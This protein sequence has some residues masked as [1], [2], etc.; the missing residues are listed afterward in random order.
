MLPTR[1]VFLVLF[2]VPTI[3]L[4]QKP[5]K[6][7]PRVRTAYQLFEAPLTSQL[8]DSGYQ[9]A[10]LQ[11]LLVG[12]KEERIL[13]VWLRT[14]TQQRYRL[15]KEYPF[16]STSG[17]LG[18]KRA[19]GDGQIPEGIYHIS[20]FNPTS[21]FLLSLQVS[22]PNASDKL[23]GQ[24]DPGGEIFI[25]GSCVTIGC[26]PITDPGIQELFVLAAQ[27]RQHGPIPVLLLPAALTPTKLVSL[28]S[29]F[30]QQ[31]QL[32]GLWQELAPVY[33]YFLQ[34]AQLPQYRI[35]KLGAYVIQ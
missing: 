11:M 18:P 19:R 13:Q 8:A 23:R 12:L 29:R 14:P 20:L 5:L 26:I 25:H 31:P 1:L 10:R 6:N 16:C 30:A 2:F 32:Q 9:F 15:W 34:H 22:Y 33:Q 35:N 7:Y 4:A 21:S 3:L 17:E 24:R 28:T 27:A